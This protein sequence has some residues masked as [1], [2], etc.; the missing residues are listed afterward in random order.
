MKQNNDQYVGDNEMERSAM[1]QKTE[2]TEVTVTMKSSK[3]INK[4]TSVGQTNYIKQN[5]LAALNRTC[6]GVVLVEKVCF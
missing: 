3:V 4:G 1:T 2:D 5:G 6:L